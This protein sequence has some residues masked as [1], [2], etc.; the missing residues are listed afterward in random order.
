MAS[1]RDLYKLF[2][3]AT[4]SKLAGAIFVFHNF[5]VHFANHERAPW[6][7][8]LPL[9]KKSTCAYKAHSETQHVECHAVPSVQ[10]ITCWHIETRSDSRQS[11][12]F[13]THSCKRLPHKALG[14]K[15]ST[16]VKNIAHCASQNL[17]H[18]EII[19]EFYAPA[20][21]ASPTMCIAT[22]TVQLALWHAMLLIA[23]C[24]TSTHSRKPT[25]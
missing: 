21:R 22:P 6:P 23:D 17:C 15:C 13:H 12:Y 20:A 16:N 7:S 18:A 1:V 2:I 4:H 14:T 9:T 25:T 24:S 11:L 10:W 19:P 3:S 5:I 8:Y